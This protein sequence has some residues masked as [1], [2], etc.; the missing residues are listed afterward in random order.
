MYAYLTPISYIHHI[1]FRTSGKTHICVL[2]D[3]VNMN[4]TSYKSIKKLKPFSHNLCFHFQKFIQCLIKIMAKPRKSSQDLYHS[5]N[6]PCLQNHASPSPNINV[7]ITAHWLAITLKTTLKLAEGEFW[8]NAYKP[9]YYTVWHFCQTILSGIVEWTKISKN[10]AAS[11]NS[12]LYYAVTYDRSR[13][14]KR[15]SALDFKDAA[16]ERFGNRN[17]IYRNTFNI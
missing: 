12:G 8:I 5:A 16:N 1:D 13:Y 2:V 6:F 11:L 17:P 3:H 10:G 15:A 7:E 14:P 4:T 9:W